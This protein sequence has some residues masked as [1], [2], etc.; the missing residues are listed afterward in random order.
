MKNGYNKE[1]DKDVLHLPL[2]SMYIR[3]NSSDIIDMKSDNV[4][5]DTSGCRIPFSQSRK[6]GFK[7]SIC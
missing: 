5:G 2:F 7:S 4:R 3:N 6:H 1:L